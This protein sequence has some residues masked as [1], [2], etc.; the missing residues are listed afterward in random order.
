MSISS[1]KLPPKGNDPS[2]EVLACKAREV[3]NRPAILFI[4]GYTSGAWQFAEYAMP[5]LAIHGWH[6]FAINLRGH[7][8][9]SGRDYVRKARFADYAQDV[10]RAVSYVKDETGKTPI[11]IGHS[12]GSVLARHYA[13]KHEVPGLGLLSFGDIKFGMKGFMGWMMKRFPLQGIVGIATGRPSAMFAKFK[14]QYAVMYEGHDRAAV[15]PNVVRLM[16]QPDS[17]KVFLEL[18]KLKIGAPRGNPLLLVLA[19]DRDPIA[20]DGSVQKLAQKLG[21]EAVV[22]PG[23]AHDILAGPDWQK[24]VGQVKEWLEKLVPTQ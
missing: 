3:S 24:G 12:L 22:L 17:D 10:E 19:G 14:P 15:A 4:H 9:S 20:S 8:G 2:L 18:G 13:A 21:I 7:G 16:A 5:E 11:L 23:Q 1:F 6:T